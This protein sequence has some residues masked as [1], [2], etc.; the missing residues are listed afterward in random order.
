VVAPSTAEGR[1]HLATLRAAGVDVVAV[2][3]PDALAEAVPAGPTVLRDGRVAAVE[4]RKGVRAVTVTTAAGAER[5]ECDTVVLSLGLAPR[6][7][8]LR[9]GNDLPVI[10][11]G[12]VVWPGCTLEEAAESGRRAAA[13]VA[14]EPRE[15]GGVAVGRR[16]YV[17]LCEDVSIGDLEQAWG[18]GWH[19][20]EILKRYTTATMGPCQGA[21]CGRILASFVTA[22]SGPGQ[23]GARTTA[24]PPARTHRLEDLAAGVHEVIDKRTSLHER[25][26]ELG[27][28]LDWS[29]S[30]KRPFNYGDVADEYRAV[31]ERVSLMDV[32]TLG[33]FLVAGRDAMTLLDRVF[34]SR[35]EGLAPWRSRYLLALDEA[36]YVM[37]D[38]MICALEAGRF[39]LT[40]TSGGADRMEAWLR[41]WA[42]R[43]D[44][45]VHLVNQTPMLG[46]INVAGPLARDLLSKL[47]DDPIDRDALPHMAHAEVTVAGVPCR[48]IR[49]GFVGELSY[50]L[51]HPRSRGIE[52]WDAL[53]AAGAGFDIRPHGLD[54]LETLRMEKGHF[55]LGQDT[56]PDDHPAKLGLGWA[57]AMDKPTFIGKVALERMADIPIERKFIGLTFDGTAPTRGVPLYAG[58]RIVGRVTSCGRSEALGKAIGLGWMRAVDGEF[59][60]ELRA[61]DTRATVTKTP[62]YDPEG[63]RLHA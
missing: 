7:A 17:C 15:G 57:V 41:N 22:K 35:I 42:D 28:H 30:W 6:D 31:R 61:G 33:K 5:F 56:L 24:R 9:M 62:F 14:P 20:S 27:A 43:W 45:H 21:M 39:Y 18:E 55:Y 63:A 16:G 48:A 37:D 58:E 11:A 29:G 4:G 49:V 51:H 60:S 2:A 13:G 36:G 34:P 38:G 52:L 54:A 8:L 19:S 59:A 47:C 10:G 12:D 25:H 26:L 46:A 3:V 1:E 44:L 50:E 32:G 40:S 23:A 53:L